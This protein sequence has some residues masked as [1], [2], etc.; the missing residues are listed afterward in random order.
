MTEV[1]FERYL[2][3]AYDNK[4]KS[5]EGAIGYIVRLAELAAEAHAG[6]LRVK[7]VPSVRLPYAESE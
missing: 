1:P 6:S 7:D 3:V 4:R 5:D 2:A